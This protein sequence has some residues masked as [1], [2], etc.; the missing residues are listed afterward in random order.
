MSCQ[1]GTAPINITT[2]P[3]STC[4][5]LCKFNYQYS[6][7]SCNVNNMEQYLKIDYDDSKGPSIIYNSISMNVDEIRMYRPSLHK[8]NGNQ[9]D[10][11]IIIKHSGNGNNL[12]VCV[13]IMISASKTDASQLFETI[14]SNVLTKAPNSGESTTINVKNFNLNSIVPEASF[15]SY[16][17][18][19]PY[20]PCTGKY[21]YVVFD[22]KDGCKITP[23]SFNDL[24]KLISK[25]T[26]TIKT[27]DFFFNKTGSK[28]GLSTTGLGDGYY[29]ECNPVDTEG[30]LLFS[31]NKDSLDSTSGGGGVTVYKSKK[32]IINSEVL[33]IFVGGVLVALII[34]LVIKRYRT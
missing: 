12:L 24:S 28:E 4:D 5:R 30:T 2:K 31:E 21:N 27:N 17:G 3:K 33:I 29:L 7:S 15:N 19:L 18:T 32:T 9:A 23:D 11:E 20:L 14:L 13:P 1:T 22:I 6:D 10:S 16:S 25:Q 34:S 26:Y 8:Y